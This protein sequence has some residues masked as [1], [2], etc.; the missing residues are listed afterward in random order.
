MSRPGE[1]RHR[2]EPE[3]QLLIVGAGP[4]SVAMIAIARALGWRVRCFAAPNELAPDYDRWTAA[5]IKTHNYGRDFA[6]LRALIPM[7]LAYIGLMGPRARRE[8]LLGDLLDTGVT[9]GAN[10]FA[11]AGLDLGAGSPETIALAVVAEIETVLSGGSGQS[12]RGRKVPIHR[13]ENPALATLL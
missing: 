13:R 1:F 8:R 3:I 12:L 11:P 9:V 2:I 10:L 7:D 5:V 4:D 6:A